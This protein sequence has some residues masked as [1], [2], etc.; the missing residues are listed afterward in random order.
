MKKVNRHS[1]ILKQLQ[2]NSAAYL[3]AGLKDFK[4]KHNGKET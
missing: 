2:Q 4:N 3:A 1:G